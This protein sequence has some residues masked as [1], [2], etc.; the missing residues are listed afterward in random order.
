MHISDKWVVTNKKKIINTWRVLSYP[1]VIGCTR[2]LWAIL[3]DY[4]DKQAHLILLE[5]TRL[6]CIRVS[7]KQ[8]RPRSGPEMHGPVCAS[9]QSR[10]RLC[11]SRSLKYNSKTSG[12]QK[13]LS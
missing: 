11:Y 12:T 9:A 5:K 1:V 6:C 10:Q 13:L 3:C 2:Q 7:F 4:E 8:P